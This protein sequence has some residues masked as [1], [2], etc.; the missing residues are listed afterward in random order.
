MVVWCKRAAAFVLAFVS[1]SSMFSDSLHAQSL[2]GTKVQ[3]TFLIGD[4]IVPLPA[5]E[6]TVIATNGDSRDTN[7]G[8]PLSRAYLAQLQGNTLSQWL[9]ISTNLEVNLAGWV[10]DKEICDRKDVHFGFSDSNYNLN[11]ASCWVLNHFGQA[12]GSKPSQAGVDF[13]RWSDSRGRPNTSLLL[14]NFFS[15]RG[16]FLRVLHHFNPVVAG[17]PDTPTATWAGNP[18][19]ADLAAKDPKKLQFLRT[20]KPVGE[21]EFDLFKAVLR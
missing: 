9:D 16:D 14:A 1:A 13:F 17:F 3:G 15:K 10:R 18:W 12:L 4:R 5:G 19:H 6:W 21:R 8:R 7:L 11:D 20:L 2:L